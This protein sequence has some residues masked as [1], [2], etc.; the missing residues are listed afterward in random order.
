[1]ESGEW[2]VE[3]EEV[4]FRRKASEPGRDRLL[5]TADVRLPT[6]RSPLSTLH[7]SL[8]LPL[9]AFGW[10]NVPML[11]WLAVA[12]VPLLIHLWSR[13]KY[14]EVSWA[15]IE[16][17]AAAV[18]R[19][20][21]RLHIEHWLLLLVRTSLIVLIVLAV[22][23]PYM[24]R[25]GFALGAAGHA[26]RVLVIDGSYSMAYRPTDKTRFERAKE[27]ARQI[28]EESPQGDA[29]TLILMAAPPRMVVG[30]PALE[31]REIVGE[32]DSLQLTHAG[33]DLPATVRMVRRM[34][35]AAEREDP[36][37]ARHEVYFLSDMQRASWAPKLSETATAE[38]QQQTSEL[39]EK[40]VLFVIDLGQPAT[41]NVAIT[42]LRAPDP[43]VMVGRKVSLVTELKNFGHEPRRH[44]PVTLLVD[45]R[46]IEQKN[47]DVA[48]ESAASIEFS[49]RFD[50]P[51]D[52]A[53]EV[54]T[55]GDGLEIDNHRFLAAPVRQAIR[56]LCID[57]RPSGEA[58][59]GAADYLAVALAPQGSK[60]NQAL[61]Q[62]NVASEAALMEGNLNKYDC[63]ALCNVA[64]FTAGE[65]RVLDDYLRCGG[66]LIFFLGDQVQADR[67]NRELGWAGDVGAGQGRATPG[68]KGQGK[69]RQPRILPARLGDVIDRAQFQIDPLGY[70]HP[71]VQTFRGR[72]E[73]SLQT[74][75]VL[76]HF[77]LTASDNARTKTVIAL[78]D[79]DPLVV[80][81]PVHR[82]RV[83]LVATSADPSWTALPL[84]PS[85]VPLAQEMVA[86]CVGGE[87]QQRNLLVG[88]PLDVSVTAAT[89]ETR[90]IIQT[91]DGRDHPIQ[92]RPAGDDSPLSYADTSQSG[93][94]I[95][96]FG[97]PVDREE[98]FA[99]NLDTVESDL[100]QID[101]DEFRDEVWPGIP[102]VHQTSWQDLGSSGPGGAIRG[103][104][105]LHIGLLYVVLGL[106]FVDTL[107]GWL[108]GRKS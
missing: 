106:L 19:Q 85:F 68:K 71:M 22:A 89:A 17:L 81:T 93:F 27:L 35:D 107:L 64:Q 28:V 26:H 69:A 54:Q 53:I 36:R 33:A 104:S 87:L 40:A 75:P 103:G 45:H 88:E 108:W 74:T 25:A 47:V 80:E 20:S 57:G 30:R 37:L 66:S 100:E 78:G 1:V 2:R 77:R 94:Y 4:L 92:P 14:R 91:P 83:V 21:R 55:T 11:G 82:G 84:W 79:G 12:A 59:H 7:C 3:S 29:F 76:K 49:Y 90:L 65:A 18:K 42:S 13:R 99:V 48:P 6:A 5:P 23:E 9:L 34:V 24:E 44:Q 56:V 58:F 86:Y 72:G 50:T 102:F 61:V 63:V 105:R 51:G 67:Y 31:P 15:A 101:P 96:Q 16:F 38:F 39:S 73:A 97:S 32:I 52:H 46:R 62:A 60:A 41:E 98:M 10:T 70:R 8:F 43:L 95:A